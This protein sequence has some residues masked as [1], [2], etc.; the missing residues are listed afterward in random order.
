[1]R[2]V[3]VVA[4][5]HQKTSYFTSPRRAAP[6]RVPPPPDP[7]RT[8]PYRTPT[9]AQPH[10]QPNHHSPTL[11]VM[12]RLIDRHGK[13]NIS[14]DVWCDFFSRKTIFE[15]METKT[16]KP[17]LSV[18]VSSDGRW[19]SYG[20]SDG[21][22]HVYNSATSHPGFSREVFLSEG[23]RGITDSTLLIPSKVSGWSSSG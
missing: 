6:R 1:M 14:Q 10:P 16:V 5:K 7:H 4:I 18:A 3:R 15:K 23:E 19:V 22:G 17:I 21:T 2:V 13:G 11:Q 20:G 12:F 9:A 8:V